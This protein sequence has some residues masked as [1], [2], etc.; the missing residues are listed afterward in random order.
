MPEPVPGLID[1][2]VNLGLKRLEPIEFLLIANPTTEFN[3]NSLPVNIL[4][5]VKTINF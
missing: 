2:L 4:I 3:L 5:K 1:I